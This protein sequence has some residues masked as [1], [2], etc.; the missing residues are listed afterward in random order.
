M[1]D[2]HSMAC[3]IVDLF[4][5]LLAE[6]DIEIPCANSLEEEERHDDDNCAYLYGTEYWSLVDQVEEYL[7]RAQ[8]GSFKM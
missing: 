7:N 4:D 1:N 5:E 6:K 8:V 2:F 3:D